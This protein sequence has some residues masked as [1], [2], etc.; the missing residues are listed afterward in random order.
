MLDGVAEI[1]EIGGCGVSAIDEGEGVA[2]GD[3]SVAHRVT[4]HEAGAFE[5]PGSG[6]LDAALCCGPVRDLV[7]GEV[8][9]LRD[10]IEDLTSDDGVF[11]E[12]ACA[13]GVGLTFY[14]QH[15][16]AVANLADG[17]VDLNGGGLAVSEVAGEI[18]IG[19]T[20]L[21]CR[22]EAEGH[23]CDD[24][25][26]AF[27]GVEEALAIGEAA[28]GVREI[29]EAGGFEIE[30]ADGGDGL[31]DLLAVGPYVLDGSSSDSSGY[32]G[33]ALD[34]ANSLLAGGK[35]EVVPLDTGGNGVF[36][37]IAVGDWSCRAIEGDA[38]DEPAE[39]GVG[40]EEVAAAP[41]G[42]DLERMLAGER[43]GFKQVGFG[44]YHTEEACGTADPQGGKGGQGDVLLDVDGGGRHGFE[45]TSGEAG[46]ARGDGLWA[47][48]VQ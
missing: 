43:N 36:E 16:L 48:P 44:R 12:G 11:E 41:Q 9:D 23:R 42:E 1:E 19:K 7:V 22:V 40:D 33:E 25:A 28:L 46:D 10:S 26:A 32:P 24:V 38:K 21:S 8:E 35:D 39:A 15:A 13:A 31:G 45:G 37:V 20:R 4:L 34:A 14:D 27:G 47:V 30:R 2:R 3:S 5:Q 6:K 29:D 17:V 18:C